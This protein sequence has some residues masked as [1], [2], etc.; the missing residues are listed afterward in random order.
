MNE[1]EFKQ[2]NDERRRTKLIRELSL[3]NRTPR[4]LIYGYTYDRK[5]FHVYLTDAGEVVRVIYDADGL[6]ISA[7]NSLSENFPLSECVPDKRL[8]PGSCDFEFC[9]KLMS[10]GCSLSFTMWSEPPDRSVIG[11]KLEQ[12]ISALSP[13]DFKVTTEFSCSDLGIQDVSQAETL[14]E[15]LQAIYCDQVEGYLRGEC[16]ERS[17]QGGVQWLL[18]IVPTMQCAI[19]HH[20]RYVSL[21]SAAQVPMPSNLAERLDSL[22]DRAIQ[23][24]E[25]ALAHL[26][27]KQKAA[28]STPA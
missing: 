9:S 8:Y 19:E 11:F 4:T 26:K 17:G 22:K 5:T 27:E 1:L 12:L 14:L 15:R 10:A 18:N 2:L 25:R 6:L 24:A 3:E 21:T 20:W 28:N 13:D 16:L 23:H 7:K